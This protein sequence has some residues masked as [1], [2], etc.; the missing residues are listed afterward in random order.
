MNN[1][2]LLIVGAGPVGLTLACQCLQHGVG[3]RIVEKSPVRSDKSKALAIWSATLEHLA[4]LEV[5]DRFYAEAMLIERII[6]QDTDRK[7][8]EMSLTEG[9]QSLHA[10]PRILPQ[11][12][13]EAVLE[14][15]LGERGVT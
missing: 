5:V 3:F 2:D 6:V 7:M 10:H 4:K 1:P 14:K 9:L 13:T 15:F 8:A 12:D 11:C